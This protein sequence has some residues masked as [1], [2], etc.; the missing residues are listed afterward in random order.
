MYQH[1]E[2]PSHEDIVA[3]TGRMLEKHPDLR[4]LGAHMGSLEYSVDELAKRLDKFPNMAVELAA[5]MGQVFYQTVENRE[6]VRKFFIK[7]QDRILYGT[8]LA[9][10]ESITKEELEDNME[11]AWKRDWEYF[12]TD[13]EMESDLINSSFQGIKLPKD[14]VDKIFYENANTWFA[15]NLKD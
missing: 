9:D 11:S 14:V 10:N 1:P 4:F 7:Y 5:R 12:V 15:L 3:S 13:N 6:K 8:D 2:M